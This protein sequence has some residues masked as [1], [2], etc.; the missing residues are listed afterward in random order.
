MHQKELMMLQNPEDRCLKNI[1]KVK[2]INDD[3]DYGVTI[4]IPNI[5]K[6]GKNSKKL[7]II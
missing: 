6:I 1:F 7:S 2:F 5:D 3:R 4:E